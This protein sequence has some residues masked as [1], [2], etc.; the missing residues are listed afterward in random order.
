MELR[1]AKIEK[2]ENQ[3]QETSFG[4]LEKS[5]N[6]SLVETG[7]IHASG[8]TINA[9]SGQS[10]FEINIQKI[11]LNQDFLMLIGLSEPRVFLSWVFYNND[12]SYTPVLQGPMVVFNSSSYYKVKLDDSFLDFLMESDVMFQVHL[13][14]KNEC[15]TFAAAWI[16]FSEILDYPQ[17][18][19]HGKASLLGVKGSSKEKSVG[20]LY[21]WFKLHTHDNKRISDFVEKRYKTEDITKVTRIYDQ[22]YSFIQAES[23]K[24]MRNRNTQESI[25]EEMPVST[26]EFRDQ[27]QKN[28]NFPTKNIPKPPT[29]TMS[30]DSLS[31]KDRNISSQQVYTSLSKDCYNELHNI[32]ESRGRNSIKEAVVE[33]KDI[34]EPERK[35][36]SH[37]RKSMLKSFTGKNVN[38]DDFF[39]PLENNEQQKLEIE[40]ALPTEMN[41]NCWKQKTKKIKED[42]NSEKMP[43]SPL[44]ISKGFLNQEKESSN[45]QKE[46]EDDNES[47]EDDDESE[48]ESG[49]EIEDEADECT[50]TE[51]TTR[52]ESSVISSTNEAG[53]AI[54]V[55]TDLHNSGVN[56]PDLSNDSHDSEGVVTKKSPSKKTSNIPNKDNIIIVVSEFEAAPQADFIRDDHVSLLYVEYSFLDIPAEELETPFSLPKPK[57]QE[58]ITFNFRKVFNVERVCN[59]SRRRLVSRILSSE[60]DKSRIL[61]FKLVSEPPDSEPDLDC[62]DIGVANID[63]GIID[64]TGKDLID[65]CLD[66]FS[67]ENPDVCIGTLTVSIQAAQAFKSIKS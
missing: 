45:D 35:T 42:T 13:A 55:T 56:G 27:N 62:E 5:L 37:M 43:N 64:R 12:Q 8:T 11:S 61:R 3:L 19:L 38:S 36:E 20:S 65:Q 63:L 50:T 2:L 52:A 29:M 40:E 60:D 6:N 46:S 23:K 14:I 7:Q 39:F 67:I 53:L 32:I 24:L 4:T 34:E 58:R 47:I 33:K 66:V 21:Y 9:A 44:S 59:S 16:K 51:A 54:T 15:Q 26:L 28:R 49:D 25:L 31:E 22:D 41:D 57:S 10:L 30:S 1:A 18:K 17:N 48:S